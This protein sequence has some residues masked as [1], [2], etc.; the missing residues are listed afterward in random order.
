[1]RFVAVIA[2]CVAS[3]AP[4]FGTSQAAQAGRGR[5]GQADANGFKAG[6]TVEVDTAFGW[7]DAQILSAD[8]NNYQVR[9]GP[10]TVLKRYPVELHRKGAFTDRDHAVGLYDL[11]DR[12]Q[13][14]MQGQG[15]IDGVVTS[16]RA[17]EYE[18]L[19]D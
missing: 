11:K 16:R 9:V 14:N 12:V 15:W 6:D 1:M 2:L 17:L 19:F 10:S 7:V 5:G 4:V 8:G 3:A 18:V 13:I